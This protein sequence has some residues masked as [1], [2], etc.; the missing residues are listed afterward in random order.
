MEICLLFSD[1]S[2]NWLREFEVRNCFCLSGQGLS[3]RFACEWPQDRS[4][5]GPFFFPFSS[6]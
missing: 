4:S 1:F 6:F 3:L 2:E 5:P